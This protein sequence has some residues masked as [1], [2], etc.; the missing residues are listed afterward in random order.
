MRLVSL[1]LG[2]PCRSEEEHALAHVS[3]SH[4]DR[5]RALERSAQLAERLER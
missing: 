3:Q 2:L 1:C 5:R 4:Q